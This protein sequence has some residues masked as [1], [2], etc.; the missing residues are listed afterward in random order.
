MEKEGKGLTQ[1]QKTA[2]TAWINFKGKKNSKRMKF[3]MDVP[4]VLLVAD[5]E[6]RM[7]RKTTRFLLIENS[8]IVL[9][10]MRA[11]RH[12]IGFMLSC[13]IHQGFFLKMVINK[14][15]L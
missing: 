8:V 14:I 3:L 10:F 11:V 6:N 15:I 4:S 1:K 12:F 13:L 5:D 2:L 9:H 7:G